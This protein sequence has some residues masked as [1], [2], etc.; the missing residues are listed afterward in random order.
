MK[1]GNKLVFLFIFLITIFQNYLIGIENAKSTARSNSI[2]QFASLL[3]ERNAAIQ[4]MSLLALRGTTS[5]KEK[6][7]SLRVLVSNLEQNASGLISESQFEFFRSE[8]VRL[9][10]FEESEVTYI[11]LVKDGAIFRL[12]QNRSSSDLVEGGPIFKFCVDEDLLVKVDYR[13]KI[14]SVEDAQ[15]LFS[16]GLPILLDHLDFAF[17]PWNAILNRNPDFLNDAFDLV[18]VGDNLIILTASDDLDSTYEFS[19]YEKSVFLSERVTASSQ[20]GSLLSRALYFMIEFEKKSEI[21]FPR[22]I[23]FDNSYSGGRSFELFL[24][25]SVGF[26]DS[27]LEACDLEVDDGFQIVDNL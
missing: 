17:L 4:N 5:D 7:E 22:V 13:N 9:Q 2:D 21:P 3:V 23:I 14:V 8:I 12:F 6:I 16:I 24:I 10:L 11:D 27:E 26:G 20:D 18:G 15:D 19:F 1:T 25:D